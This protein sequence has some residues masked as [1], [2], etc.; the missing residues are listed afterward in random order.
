M[1]KKPKAHSSDAADPTSP[2]IDLTAEE[3]ALGET[4]PEFAAGDDDPAVNLP[5]PPPPP[6]KKRQTGLPTKWWGRIALAVLAAF[7]GAWLYKGYGERFWPSETMT[8]MT[9]RLSTL[10]AESK[11]LNG[12]LKGLGASVD[13]LKSAAQGSTDDVKAAQAA[14]KQALQGTAV[15][16]EQVRTL[17]EKLSTTDA[18]IAAAQKSIDA[19]KTAL[20]GFPAQTEGQVVANDTVALN[21]IRSRLESVEKD[22]AAL[23]AKGPSAGAEAATVLSQTLSDLKAKISTGAPF[24]E[25]LRRI[26]SLVPAAS[27]LSSLQPFAQDGVATSKMLADD[28]RQLASKLVPPPA[29]ATGEESYWDTLNHV[30]GDVVTVRSVGDINWQ[31][32]A[33]KAADAADG[34]NLLEAIALVPADDGVPDELRVWR[35]KAEARLKADAAVED[36]SQAVLRQIAAI[37]G[38]Q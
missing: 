5:P 15:A 33:S 34:G 35:G 38:G 31:D 37:G 11:T 13:E 23:K 28:A 14:G 24:S 21:E 19:L 2:V 25:E 12:Q 17:G 16:Q 30:L 26:S 6:E 22:V 36:V 20:A 29:P 4:R 3:I 18:R 8:D 10:E 1:A 32:V 9:A 27:G 7:A